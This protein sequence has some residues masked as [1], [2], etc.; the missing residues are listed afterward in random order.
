MVRVVLIGDTHVGSNYAILPEGFKNPEDGSVYEQNKWQRKMF[1]EWCK[2]AEKLSPVDV[3]I[4]M[5]DLVDGNQRRE[6]WGTL[7]I[8]NIQIQA[9]CFIKMLQDTWKW[10]ELYVVRG[11]DYHDT[12]QGVHIDEY[13]AQRLNARKPSDPDTGKYSADDIQLRIGKRVFH[14]AHKVTY[15]SVPTYRYAPLARQMWLLKLFDEYYGKVDIVVR[16][17]VHYHIYAGFDDI[18]LALTTPAW[19]LP[20]P[21]QRS[22]DPATPNTIGLIEFE[23]QPDGEYSWWLHKVPGF[24]PSIVEVKLEQL[25]EAATVEAG[26]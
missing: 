7:K 10:R 19:Q 15:S 4:L 13:I 9:E 26:S 12:V 6:N 14:L 17:H 25:K 2:L 11:T 1:N 22:K 20:T 16:A 3:L 5:G 23:I 8:Q 21:Y 18:M 24:K